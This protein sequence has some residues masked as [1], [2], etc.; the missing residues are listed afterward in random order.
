MNSDLVELNELITQTLHEIVNG[1]HGQSLDMK[2]LGFRLHYKLR[3]LYYSSCLRFTLYRKW[4][5]LYVK[6]K[7]SLHKAKKSGKN[8]S[9]QALESML[10]TAM[11][12]SV[13]SE[14]RNEVFKKAAQQKPAEGPARGKVKRQKASTTVSKE[15][16]EGPAPKKVKRQ[17][18]STTVSK[19]EAK[20]PAPKKVK[21]QVPVVEFE[22]I[23]SLEQLDNPDHVRRMLQF[24]EKNG[25]ICI[26]LQSL[27]DVRGAVKDI[28]KNIF[29]PMPYLTKH[30]LNFKGLDGKE[31][32]IDN[33]QDIDGIVDVM[34]AGKLSA[35]NWK[36]LRMCL[37]P[38]ATFGGPCVP[39][40]FH[41]KIQNDIRQNR[42][43]YRVMVMLLGLRF[44]NAC[45]NRCYFRTPMTSGDDMLHFDCN[46]LKFE[47]DQAGTVSAT[48]GIQGKVAITETTFV[49][50]PGTH[51]VD[52]LD[53]FR[54]LYEPLY[55][56]RK[57]SCTMYGLSQD[58]DPLGLFAQEVAF[59]VP[60]CCFV[61]WHTNIL[62][63]H[64][65]KTTKDPLDIGFFLGYHPEVSAEQGQILRHL[66]LTGGTPKM[67]PSGVPFH[68]FPAKF[69]NFPKVMEKTVVERL[70]PEAHAEL[71]GKRLTK[72][73]K[74]VLDVKPWGWSKKYPFTPYDFT[75]FG[76]CVTGQRPWS[77][78]KEDMPDGAQ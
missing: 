5:K 37:P 20:G 75:M 9:P 40:S 70:T 63:S 50:V 60:K 47:M 46:P 71:V 56:G 4:K 57:E 24:W 77:D 12:P 58:R 31:L 17:M 22:E 64:P 48:N 59:R 52:F 51:R 39:G 8:A 7:T 15:K 35:E 25:I 44:I 10:V 53:K 23:F 2:R 55:P 76:E 78:F 11:R 13:A 73:R 72:A 49:C 69:L 26:D 29:D 65:S 62:H 42:T 3:Q 67:W 28:V 16:A 34:L 30:R 32:H 19:E 6:W 36:R 14:T 74:K 27:I 41:T 1:K 68:F 21:R 54:E 33:E 61:G 18:D 66:H 45:F 43:L 38:H